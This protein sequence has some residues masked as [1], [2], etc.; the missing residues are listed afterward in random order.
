MELS[1]HSDLDTEWHPFR[2][3][4]LKHR[5]EGREDPIVWVFLRPNW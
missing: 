2:Q 4:C 5:Y 3:C 1:S